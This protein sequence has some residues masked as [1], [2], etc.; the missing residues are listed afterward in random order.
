MSLS[1][2]FSFAVMLCMNNISKVNNKRGRQ[3][4]S[5]RNASR[6]SQK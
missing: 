1:K 2:T 6:M 3:F 4:S 5:T